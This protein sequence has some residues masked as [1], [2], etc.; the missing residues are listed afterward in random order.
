M[1]WLCIEKKKKKRERER[2]RSYTKSLYKGTMQECKKK[3]KK[4]NCIV[5]RSYK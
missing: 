2:E 1:T 5:E 3:K 4:E